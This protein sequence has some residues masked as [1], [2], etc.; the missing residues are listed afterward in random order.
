MAFTGLDWVRNRQRALARAVLALFCLVWMQA[1]L[2]PC[3]MAVV[4]DGMSSMGEEHCVYCP[5]GQ[6]SHGSDEAGTAPACLYPDG[7]KADQRPL[8]AAFAAP[9]LAA[10][11][12]TLP[13][14]APESPESRRVAA[15]EVIPHP[16]YSVAYCRFLK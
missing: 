16:D 12:F 1:A 4:P 10:S 6:G 13:V 3:A 15:P 2:L 8:V 14:V 9:L 11:V 7:A 5:E